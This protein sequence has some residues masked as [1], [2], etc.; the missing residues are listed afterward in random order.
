MTNR[1]PKF[2]C[3]YCNKTEYTH[4]ENNNN[5]IIADCC[6]REFSIDYLYLHIGK[7]LLHSR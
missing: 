3:E 2:K 5:I 7:T 1:E 6:S 4:S